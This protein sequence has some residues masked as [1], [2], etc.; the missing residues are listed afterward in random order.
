MPTVF[1]CSHC[2]EMTPE[3]FCPTCGHRA[4]VSRFDCD[5]PACRGR[6]DARRAEF[7]AA[8]VELESE[9][10]RMANNPHGRADR[11]RAAAGYRERAA[12]IAAKLATPVG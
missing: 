1:T 7:V 8:A 3:T 9:A 10:A 5:C 2:H 11:L 6:L 4:D 12:M